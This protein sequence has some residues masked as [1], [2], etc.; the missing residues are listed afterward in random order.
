MDSVNLRKYKRHIIWTILLLCTIITSDMRIINYIKEEQKYQDLLR[1][2]AYQKIIH[3]VIINNIDILERDSI[4]NENNINQQI[5]KIKDYIKNQVFIPKSSFI[6][7]VYDNQFGYINLQ[8]LLNDIS[9]QIFDY[10]VTVNDQQ[11]AGHGIINARNA[12]VKRYKLTDGLSYNIS[13]QI[14]SVHAQ[15]IKE[16]THDQILYLI[17][18]SC[19][20]FSC[21]VLIGFYCLN[22]NQKIN[23]KIEQLNLALHNAIERNKNIILFK[24]KDKEF[25]L[26]CYQ[27]SKSTLNKNIS[28]NLL[29]EFFI[30]ENKSGTEEYL[31]L[32][33]VLEGER[34]NL[35]ELLLQPIIIE[36]Q[37]YFN[38]YVAYYNTKM[39]LEITNTVEKITVPFD[40]EVFTQIIF[41]LFCNILYF[42]KNLENLKFIKLTFKKNNITCSSN[43]FLLDHNLAIRYS[44]RIFNDTG[45]LYLLNLGQ[46]FVLLKRYKLDYTVLAK[47]QETIIEIKLNNKLVTASKSE[48]DKIKVINFTKFKKKENHKC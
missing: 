31:P 27:Y 26:K 7:G 22:K 5:V 4:N 15:E 32:P 23:T 14:N 3:T 35:C 10:L 13:V 34:T 20:I 44:E 29:T 43:G 47:G 38:G 6:A 46:I 9:D 42:N 11:I 18:L 17:I 25:I 16:R 28:E 33:L 39:T 30:L 12:L 37:E 19:V 8:E 48:K 21:T 36:L 40:K 45:N 41:S 24:E 1:L 2:L